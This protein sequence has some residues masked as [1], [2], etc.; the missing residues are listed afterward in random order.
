M[1]DKMNPQKQQN[2]KT[3]HI[4]DDEIEVLEPD[5][6]HGEDPISFTDAR[7]NDDLM[8]LAASLGTFI[9]IPIGLRLARYLV[10]P[11][12]LIGAFVASAYDNTARAMLYGLLAG[13]GTALS[14]AIGVPLSLTFGLQVGNSALL[15]GKSLSTRLFISMFIALA[16]VIL[17]MT[18]PT[19]LAIALY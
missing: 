5:A 16:G 19:K 11:L 13:G 2:G 7:I 18:L 14:F 4:A 3:R 15:A 17:V 1:I 12:A 6:I 9:S 10:L 8:A